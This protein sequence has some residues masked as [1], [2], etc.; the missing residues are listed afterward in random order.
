M[1]EK[2]DQ[3]AQAN[4][5]SDQMLQ[6]S[7]EPQSTESSRDYPNLDTEIRFTNDDE[8]SIDSNQ[9]N[10]ILPITS[11]STITNVE[12]AVESPALYTETNHGKT[13]KYSVVFF[14]FNF[15]SVTDNTRRITWNKR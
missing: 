14:Y 15:Y 5:L 6:Q 8:L 1:S 10:L 11:T 3:L 12:T 7:N 9:E 4:G 13:D 2:L